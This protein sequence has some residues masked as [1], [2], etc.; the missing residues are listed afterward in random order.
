MSHR[1]PFY[2]LMFEA[3]VGL[4]VC[5]W[6]IVMRVCE[7]CKRMWITHTHNIHSIHRII[8]ALLWAPMGKYSCRKL[9]L[10]QRYNIIFSIYSSSRATLSSKFFFAM[11]TIFAFCFKAFKQHIDMIIINITIK[12]YQFRTENLFCPF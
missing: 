6:A 8:S 5:H 7:N 4:H 10:W 1:P 12:L 2:R 11:N 9:D 3:I